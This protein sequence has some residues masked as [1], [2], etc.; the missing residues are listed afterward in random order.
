LPDA[1]SP[2][3]YK[4]NG[5]SQQI[6]EQFYG[7]NNP[8][9]QPIDTDGTI[10]YGTMFGRGFGSLQESLPEKPEPL[11]VNCECTLEELYM[12]AKKTVEFMRKTLG[13]DQRLTNPINCKKVID[14]RPG[15]GKSTILR[16]KNEGNESP[17]FPNS[18]LIVHIVP[19][20]HKYYECNG[21]DLIYIQ[22]VSL[23]KALSSDP[24]LINT[25]DGRQLLVAIDEVINPNSLKLIKGEGMPLEGQTGMKGDL[26][27]KF[28]IE[29]PKFIPEEKKAY[30]RK[31]LAQ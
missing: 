14:I 11:D 7:A 12:G 23:L 24:L 30:L 5:N 8:F 10:I 9:V 21:N 31:A 19:L 27:I 2:I 13:I 20:S 1:S 18:D 26:Y 4:Y 16:F 15:F 22:S 28:N 29:F 6:F 25:I 17:V 3:C